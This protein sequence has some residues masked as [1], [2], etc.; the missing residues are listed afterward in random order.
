[1]KAGRVSEGHGQACGYRRAKV[2]PCLP[3]AGKKGFRKDLQ[4]FLPLARRQW[5][6]RGSL[7]TFLCTP[8]SPYH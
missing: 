7:S 2:G 3:G 4:S 6:T 5:T 1:M 8:Q